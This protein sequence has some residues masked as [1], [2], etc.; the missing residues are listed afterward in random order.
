M[1][2]PLKRLGRDLNPNNV[3]VYK[4]SNAAVDVKVADFGLSKEVETGVVNSMTGFVGSPSYIAPEVLSEH[5]QYNEKAD[6]Y[7][8]GVL[9]WFV[10]QHLYL[11]FN[12][13]L[14]RNFQEHRSLMTP[15]RFG[16]CLVFQIQFALAVLRFSLAELHLP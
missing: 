11:S 15:Y 7:S 4:L 1:V 16:E 3:L 10:S 8:F 9:T 13:Q 14:Y 6:V 12:R 5:A 2:E